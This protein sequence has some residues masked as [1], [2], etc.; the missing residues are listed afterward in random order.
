[1]RIWLKR[2]GI[3]CLIPIVLV[4]LVS[5]LLY[6]PPIQNAVVKKAVSYVSEA[7]GMVVD[8][9]RLRLSFPL[10]LSVHN[11]FV[12]TS[13]NDT[14]IHLNKLTLDVKPR[15]LLKGN[16]I[17]EGL[18]LE[19]LGLNTGK[20]LDG[21]VVKG[22]VG[23][24]YLS[25]GNVEM[26]EERVSLNNVSLSDADIDLFYCDTTA[27]DTT[28]SKV[29]WCIDLR[30][31]ELTNVNFACRMPCDSV[32]LD[33]MVNDVALSDV[34]LDLGSEEYRA[35][36]LDVNMSKLFYGTNLEEAAP[37]LDFSH[38]LL[39]DINLTLDSLY[40]DNEQNISAIL[41]K[42]SAKERSGLV[43][44]SAAGRVEVDSANIRMPSFLVET[45]YSTIQVQASVPWTAIDDK[46]P[47]GKLSFNAKALIDKHDALLIIGD[48]SE[49]FKKYYPDT[50][51][52]FE[53]FVSGNVGDFMVNKFD[54][55]LPGAFDMSMTGNITSLLNERLRSGMIDCK[56]NTQDVDFITG[57]FP[58]MLQNRFRI[59]DSMAFAGIFTM[60]KG[61]YS[62]EMV[63]RESLGKVNLSGNYNVFNES[64]E[65]YLD[66]DSLEPV[67][68]MPEDSV[69]WLSASIKAKGQGS[70]IYVSST[71][72]DIKGSVNNI[73]YG[74]S[75]ISDISI[76]GSL[77]DNHIQVELI[78]AYPFVRGRISVDGEVKKD[79][80]KGMIIV[81]ADS[82]DLYGL[83]LTEIPMSS[84]F[85]IF[86]EVESDLDKIHS[87]D[88]TL[89]NWSLTFEKQTIEP[90]MLTLA[91]RSDTNMTKTTF[92]AGDLNM[93]FTGSADFNTLTGNLSQLSGEVVKQFKR[94]STFDIQELRPFF[95]DM[96]LQLSAER[97]NPIYNYLQTDN[98]FFEKISLGATISPE[99]GLKVSGSLFALVKDTF[100]IDTIG[101]NVWQDTLG[102]LYNADAVKNRF[103]NQEAF[104]VNISGY[105][106]KNDGDIFLSFINNKGEKGVD[107]GVN[108]KKAYDR[109]DLSF[110]PEKPVIAFL[111]FTVNSNNYFRF[112]SL[113]DMEADIRLDGSYNSSF[114]IH[115]GNE[116]ETMKEI[117]VELNQI[118]LEKI[119][120]GFANMPSLKGLLNATLRY[121]PE[122]ASFMVIADGNIDDF[123]YENGRVGE[124]LVNATYMPMEKGTHQIDVHA[125]HDM[126]EISSLSVLY[127][128]GRYEDRIDGEI[129]VEQLPLNIFNAMIPG[130]MAQLEGSLHGKL[131]L[132]G[133]SKNPII[134]GALQLNKT[135]LYIVPSATTLHFDD[136]PVIVTKNKMKLDKYSLYILSKENPFII[137]GTIDAT[138]TS[139]PFVDLKMTANNLQ[140]IDSKRTA[141]SL[142]YGRLFMNVNTTLR[143]PV[144]SLIMR[145]NMRILGNTNMTYVM[146]D[147]P[148]EVQD[149]FNDLVTFTY[150]AD[151][152]PRRP[153]GSYSLVR[154]TRGVAMMS[155][156]DVLLNINIDPVVRIR[157]DLS[158]DRS[159]Y[160]EWRGG[161]DLSLQYTTQ[162][163]MSLNGRYT[164]SD[165][166]M[167]YSIPVIPL[168]D[169]SIRNGSYVDWNGNPM[170]PYLN[171]T[172][173]TRVRS[174]VV[175]NGQS[176]MVDFNTGI[177]LRDNL[178]DVSVK[179][180]LEAPNND[181]VRS[182]LTAM[183]EE[184]RSKQAISL[185]V[186]G[187]YLASGGTG[188][189]NLNVG[190]ALNSL[191]QREI[192]NMLGN[193]MGEVPFS[194]DVITY[195]GTD[196]KGRRVDYMGRFYK[197]FFGERLYTTLGLR[198]TSNNE[199]FPDDISFEYK[200][201]TDGGRA[202]K[203]FRSS[204]YK[205]I[206]EG[207]I[208]NIGA[209]FILKRKV[210][211]F[212]DLF[213]LKKNKMIVVEKVNDAPTDDSS[214]TEDDN[215][216]PEDDSVATEDAALKQ[217]EGKNKIE[218]ETDY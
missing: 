170:D 79:K 123:Y 54:A 167:R 163:D 111:P 86:S 29:N 45:D 212:G 179:F 4:L 87:L 95:P 147:S 172:A 153:R 58:D 136:R 112:R 191:L 63:L 185:L 113:K 106:R 206:F 57:M 94:D 3:I 9:E 196:G 133:T 155:G 188:S 7:T 68:F 51:L 85:Q 84:S 203:V 164:L 93:V 80:I 6:V 48:K 16:V 33:I 22:N 69:M 26:A 59:P 92:R 28:A 131:S 25:A 117:L 88:V 47:S 46:K 174:S 210:K 41:R 141:E 18:R 115:S 8:F 118:N 81:D 184:E 15:P 91:F 177:Q 35:S 169:F 100:K 120:G 104:K 66:I 74:E 139:H 208:T 189:D 149:S 70:D 13:D 126:K 192:K 42:C 162:G 144:Q 150:F 116:S 50:V 21:V 96:S 128:E 178:E 20:L 152:L 31:M 53:T 72:S 12:F 171:I 195:D 27:S 75:S 97:D 108:I 160:L 107:L 218:N 36:G 99:D 2:L 49:V 166:T 156:T 175:T 23:N 157:V 39:S 124:L 142:A 187:V 186:A 38:I 207:E 204:E 110:Y 159:N 146:T 90:K 165:G 60:D 213:S 119:S 135:S 89:G 11:V 132:M 176:Q 217:E 200:I 143:G 34:F 109:F 101:F 129:S 73:R 98:I 180:L 76:A 145:G 190:A 105:V 201:D 83:K 151:T 214:I 56:A 122:D 30:K 197:G 65:A 77:K 61:L 130:Q 154:G 173:Y 127:K 148:L 1:M 37:G 114:W 55:V 103:R 182:Q 5:V 202:V 82:L 134:D 44:K 211:K 52:T 193:L 181:N 125:F 140:L 19:A 24:A 64:Y 198:Y 216:L 32:F 78:S 138:N 158:E 137:D 67:H 43:V 194:F 199:F 71:W 17:V 205:N 14:L 168:T 102:I 10:G 209:S 121:V 40:Y 161:G 62:V 183:G 215:D